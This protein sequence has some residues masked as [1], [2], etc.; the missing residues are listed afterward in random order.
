MSPAVRFHTVTVQGR[1]IVDRVAGDPNLP[2]TVLL[3]GFPS[4]SHMFRNL[5]PALADRLHAVAPDDLGFGCSDAPP[6]DE[7][8]STLEKTAAAAAA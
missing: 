8:G 1:N 6:A 5:I 2:A 7:F 4:R 3:H